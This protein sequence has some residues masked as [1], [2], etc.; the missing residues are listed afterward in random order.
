M[1][2]KR[3]ITDEQIHA[4]VK[5]GIQEH[6]TTTLTYWQSGRHSISTGKPLSQIFNL[7]RQRRVYAS[8]FFGHGTWTKYLQAH[9]GIVK[10][11]VEK[12]PLPRETTKPRKTY[13]DDEIHSLISEEIQRTGLTST[14]DWQGKHKTRARGNL[15]NLANA[16]N[17]FGYKNWREYLEKRHK[18]VSLQG[19][20]SH[21]RLHATIA[22]LSQKYPVEK[23]NWNEE[24][25]PVAHGKS[26]RQL[27]KAAENQDFFGYD[28][29][30]KYVE[31]VKK[32]QMQNG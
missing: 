31:W 12:T 7:A 13:T 15:Y 9:H 24:K 18:V 5:Q 8:K 30:E 28:S 29:W 19:Q 25:K 23:V 27:F 14:T 6:G 21:D 4:W 1:V 16:R 22:T 3:R 2:Q 10:S 20:W 11:R 32:Q 17:F 26:L